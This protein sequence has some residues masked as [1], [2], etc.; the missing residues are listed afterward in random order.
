MTPTLLEILMIISLGILGGTGTGLF[1][2]YIAR[3]QERDFALMQKKEIVTN[4]LLILVCSA[5]IS[6]VLGW[7]LFVYSG[8]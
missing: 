5:A 8:A 7:Y 3:K 6:A 2:G 4:V 1:I